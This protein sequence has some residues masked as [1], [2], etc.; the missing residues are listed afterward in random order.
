[1]QILP[2]LVG[3]W[4]TANT[5]LHPI[6]FGDSPFIIM[7]SLGTFC[8]KLLTFL[9]TCHLTA[10]GRAPRVVLS[11]VLLCN[12]ERIYRSA[13]DPSAGV[14]RCTARGVKSGKLERHYPRQWLRVVVVTLAG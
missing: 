14:G 7:N 8:S 2:R 4:P 10:D 1:M 12:N 3:Y 11:V 6:L 9:A 13:G 5:L